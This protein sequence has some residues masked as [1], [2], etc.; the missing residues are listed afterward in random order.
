MHGVAG[1]V[2]VTAVS[3]A[4]V[5]GLDAGR[6]YNTWPDMNGRW[7]PEEY[8]L[9]QMGWWQNTFENTAAVQLHHRVLATT[10][11]VAVTAMYFRGRGLA[12]GGMLGPTT[13][14][15]LGA[16]ALIAWC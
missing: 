8:K 5:A 15:V 3:G 14:W 1:L 13:E 12:M 10:T 7:I 9:P 2:G 16:T 4:F 6:A 11:L